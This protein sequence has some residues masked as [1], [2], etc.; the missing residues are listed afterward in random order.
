MELETSINAYPAY[1]D[2]W[3]AALK[4][5]GIPNGGTVYTGTVTQ[6]YNPTYDVYVNAINPYSAHSAQVKQ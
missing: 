2:G 4:A 1:K 5:C 6:L 3:N